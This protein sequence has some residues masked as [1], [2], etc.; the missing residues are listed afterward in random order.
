MLSCIAAI[1][2]GLAPRKMD[3]V[4]AEIPLMKSPVAATSSWRTLN[5]SICSRYRSH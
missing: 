1:L 4:M 5:V 2:S 3:V